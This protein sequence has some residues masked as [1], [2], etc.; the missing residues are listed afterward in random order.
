MP[1][2][3]TK[4]HQSPREDV[5]FLRSR[6]V[7][8]VY[9]AYLRPTSRAR[10]RHS[11]HYEPADQHNV[12]YRRLWQA[13]LDHKLKVLVGAERTDD[14]LNEFPDCVNRVALPDADARRV[15]GRR[16]MYGPGRT[17]AES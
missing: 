2:A 12:R 5:L 6:P 16:G 10:C 13:V 15:V 4:F 9:V 11:Q 17:T 3:S 1:P 7:I 14:G 8:S